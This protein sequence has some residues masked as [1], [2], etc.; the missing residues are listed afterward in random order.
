MNKNILIAIILTLILSISCKR[1]SIENQTETNRIESIYSLVNKSDTLTF[2]FNLSG[3]ISRR[4]DFV[5]FFKVEDELF[6][7]TEIKN[8]LFENE[9]FKT[10]IKYELSPSDSVSFE[11]LLNKAESI[12]V[13]SRDSI[14]SR[15]IIISVGKLNQWSNFYAIDKSNDSIN[16]EYIRL[17]ISIMHRLYPDLEI[18]E[19]YWPI[20]IIEDTIENIEF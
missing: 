11:Y 9:G 2:V 20:E 7:T 18:Y 10:P 13:N 19:P 1:K 12:K 6:L 14:K 3:S 4:L 5:R 16:S 8:E 17:Y 15:R